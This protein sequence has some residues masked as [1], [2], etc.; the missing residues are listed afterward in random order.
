MFEKS[1]S[2][3]RPDQRSH[4]CAA[5]SHCRAPVMIDGE[6]EP[7][8]TQN[9]GELCTA[10]EN[11]F[12]GAVRRLSKDW[13]MLRAT[14]G[15]RYTEE[16]ARVASSRNMG[17]P[18]DA[19]SDRL[20][21]EMV[22]WAGYAADLVSLQLNTDTPDG[23]RT[24]AKVMLDDELSD[25]EAGSVAELTWENTRPAEKDR[26]TAYLHLIEPNLAVLAQ[27]P[28]D[29]V[30]VWAQPRRCA[31]HGEEIAAARRLLDLAR[32]IRDDDEIR[33]AAKQL[34]AAYVHAG[35]C[36]ECCGWSADG[37]SQAR[38]DMQ[39]SGLDVLTRLAR[40][41]KLS[42]EHLGQ[43]KLRHRYSMP[44]TRCG[45]TLG[46]DDGSNIITCDNK[47]CGA[48]WTEREYQFLTSL[49]VDDERSLKITKWLLAEGYSR[50]DR[51]AN[52]IGMLSDDTAAIDHPGAGRIILEHLTEIVDGHIPADDR[53]TATNKAAAQKRQAAEDSWSW[54]R[55][56]P[57]QRPERK[58]RS[59]RKSVGIAAS[60]L[61]LMTDTIP[62]AAG[63]VCGDCNLVHAGECT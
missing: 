10:C 51:I 21:T 26:L 61:S 34:Q 62:G 58:A 16:R 28:V 56:R 59:E 27:A 19:T 49:Y 54:K 45:A 23:S 35:D 22:E 41:H 3:A 15:D 12:G 37:R 42:R 29:T 8:F 36:N 63:V 2:D 7:G 5:G 57:Y 46:R 40:L 53:K 31:V 38:T 1:A 20:M 18:I 33:D 30:Q 52:L 47:E 9:A 44:C 4:R 39:I 60:S 43:T 55:E 13:S 14:L 48:S 24:L 32:G 6:Q 50:L 17:I 11:H 25:P